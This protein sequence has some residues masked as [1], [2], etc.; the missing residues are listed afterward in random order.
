VRKVQAVEQGRRDRRTTP[1]LT[2]YLRTAQ[3]VIDGAGNL[4]NYNAM[5]SS[6]RRGPSQQALA[7]LLVSEVPA[8]LTLRHGISQDQL[9]SLLRH[10]HR[11]S[12]KAAVGRWVERRTGCCA[13]FNSFVIDGAG[14]LNANSRRHGILGLIAQYEREGKVALGNVS[15]STPLPWLNG[16][17]TATITAAGATFTQE[18]RTVQLAR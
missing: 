11:Q 15:A 6:A 4:V 3:N 16:L 17:V 12:W 14:N 13:G 9:C 10:R 1:D 7:E 8:R 18:H 5:L 2:G